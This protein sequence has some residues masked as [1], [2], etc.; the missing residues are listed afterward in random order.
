M[1]TQQD[2]FARE[3]AEGGTI[4]HEECIWAS[5][6][7]TLFYDEPAA[8][9]PLLDCIGVALFLRQPGA[10]QAFITLT[11]IEIAPP[12]PEFIGNPPWQSSLSLLSSIPSHQPSLLLPILPFQDQF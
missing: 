9:S 8:H 10:V 12:R 4:S 11:G 6:N 2:C 1:S 3:N 5:Q 7:C